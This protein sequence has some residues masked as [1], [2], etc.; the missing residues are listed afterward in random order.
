[1]DRCNAPNELGFAYCFDE[2]VVGCSCNY[3]ASFYIYIN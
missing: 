1:M 3:D 2:L